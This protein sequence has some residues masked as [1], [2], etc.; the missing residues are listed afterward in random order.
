VSKVETANTLIQASAN[1]ESRSAIQGKDEGG[2]VALNPPF[3]G[4]QDE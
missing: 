3:G 1:G 4:M 2:S